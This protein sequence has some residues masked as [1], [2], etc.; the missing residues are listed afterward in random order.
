MTK[1]LM[2]MDQ[3]VKAANQRITELKI[4]PSHHKARSKITPRTV[5]YYLQNGYI[6]EATRVSG[7]IRF[8][9]DHLKEII[10]LKNLQADGL[11]LKETVRNFEK[12]KNTRDFALVDLK[13]PS[14]RAT[15]DQAERWSLRI[16]DDLLLTG[17][18]PKPSS[19]EF[20]IVRPLL[21]LW[22]QNRVLK[23]NRR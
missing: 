9:D 12:G 2:S 11:F 15:S 14:F 10:R 22:Q 4:K 16:D 18:G 8:S 23:K 20:E 6:H 21:Q 17:T 19:K 5:R 7:Q 3:L 13:I 1:S